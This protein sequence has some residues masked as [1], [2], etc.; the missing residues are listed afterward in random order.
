MGAEDI[1]EETVETIEETLE[2]LERIPKLH[3]NGTTTKQQI[4]I[5]T[6]TALVS[7]LVSGGVAHIITKKVLRKRY[8]VRLESELESTKKYYAKK[9]KTGKFGDPVKLATESL[10]TQFE[11]SEGIPKTSEKDVREARKSMNPNPFV[12]DERIFEKYSDPDPSPAGSPSLFDEIDDRERAARQAAGEAYIITLDEFNENINEF[13]QGNLTYFSGDDTLMDSRDEEVVS[14]IRKLVG[15]DT[16]NRFGQ[17]S[18]DPRVVYVRN[19]KLG[20]DF[21]IALSE[22]RYEVEVL[23]E[24]D[25]DSLQHSDRDRRLPGKKRR[26]GRNK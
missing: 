21:E 26:Q 2:T 22:N 16:L 5:L 18:R 17:G 7:A 24:P 15:D 23:G 14:D 4:I 3:L 1:L 10:L 20:M 19:E 12:K 9:E 8:D 6:A 13:G 25:P 11:Y